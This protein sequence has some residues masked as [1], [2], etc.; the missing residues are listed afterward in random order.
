MLQ[1]SD[2]LSTSGVGGWG[3]LDCSDLINTQGLCRQGWEG[4]LDSNKENALITASCTKAPSLRRKKLGLIHKTQLAFKSWQSYQYRR[5]LNRQK[6]KEFNLPLFSLNSTHSG[7]FLSFQRSGPFRYRTAV[8]KH[9]EHVFFLLAFASLCRNTF[10][11][12]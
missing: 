7:G 11:A 12:T 2:L 1:G 9:S 4:I 8:F 3:G 6:M 10:L 5:A